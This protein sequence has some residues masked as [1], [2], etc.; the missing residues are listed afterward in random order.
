LEPLDILDKMVDENLR[1]FIFVITLK[2]ETK[3]KTFVYKLK[4][5]QNGFG[6][7]WVDENDVELSRATSSFFDFLM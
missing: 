5:N 1:K 6:F 3:F 7:T 2:K 4:P